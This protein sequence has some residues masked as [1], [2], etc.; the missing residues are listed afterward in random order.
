MDVLEV[1]IIETF[2]ERCSDFDESCP[3]CQAWL[4]LDKLRACRTSLKLSLPK[5]INRMGAN[6]DERTK[7]II[8]DAMEAIT[9]PNYRGED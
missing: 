5:L 3:C 2:G 1:A 7:Q 6:E 8:L 9:E 4:E